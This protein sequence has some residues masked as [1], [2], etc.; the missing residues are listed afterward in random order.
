MKRR[1]SRKSDRLGS[2]LLTKLRLLT[3]VLPLLLTLA[4]G[5]GVVML[6]S[7]A[8]ANMEPWAEQHMIRF[9]IG[10]GL[11][12]LIALVNIR[13]IMFLAYP[14][15]AIALAAL[16]FLEFYGAGTVHR[17]IEIGGLRVQPSEFMKIA[18]VLAIACYFHHSPATATGGVSIGHLLIPLA[19]IAMPFLLIMR[20]PDLGTALVIGLTGAIVF[21]LV[22][23]HRGY[24]IAAA[25]VGAVL[26][27]LLWQFLLLPYQ[28]ERVLTFLSP[29]RDPLG[30][31]YHSLQSI[32]AVGSGQSYGRG[33]LQGAQSHLNFLPE[34]ETDFIF[35]MFAEEFGFAGGI[36]LLL[37]YGLILLC[38]M[39]MAL[40]C[41]HQFGR[42]VIGGVCGVFFLHA[43]VNIAM[44]T[45]LFPIV[46]LPLPLI[47]H[48]GT[49]LLS[50]MIGFGLAMNAYVN[51]Q[52]EL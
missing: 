8:E 25:A 27:P 40:K 31:G 7:A 50:F 12:L 52:Q 32:T 28:K 22:G 46:G 10:M 45:G 6:Y 35:T 5:V 19:L 34:K 33:Y 51:R 2:R 17:W 29:M 44:T 15:Y 26:A 3:P 49:S 18:L 24:F 9:A 41:R 36:A 37:L 43:A 21:V 11:L 23:V 16:L 47:S 30:A 4:A 38:G 39:I 1:G 48:G 13:L 42:L 20:Q 14:G